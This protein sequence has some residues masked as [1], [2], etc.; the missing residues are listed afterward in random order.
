MK[1]YTKCPNPSYSQLDHSIN[2]LE[3]VCRL[4]TTAKGSCPC[5]S[6]K[7]EFS[8]LDRWPIQ[9]RFRNRHTVVEDA[10][11]RLT[12]VVPRDNRLLRLSVE[13]PQLGHDAR[14]IMR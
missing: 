3:V 11:L 8:A 2:A 5:V 6:E 14:T 13:K 9:E 7:C 10:N 1:R 12:R 4:V